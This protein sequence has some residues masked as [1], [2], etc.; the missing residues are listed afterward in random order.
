M[1]QPPLPSSIDAYRIPSP[2][3]S[4]PSCRRSHPPSP[5]VDS[6]H[7]SPPYNRCRGS[8]HSPPPSVAL[9]PALPAIPIEMLPTCKRFLIVQRVVDVE[10]EI[11]SVREELATASS[12][13]TALQRDDIAKDV[14]EAGL[15]S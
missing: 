5:S 4:G 10:R 6:P 14:R 1:P 13:I 3:R 15:E 7:P 8:S 11:A 9:V 12:Q 2:T